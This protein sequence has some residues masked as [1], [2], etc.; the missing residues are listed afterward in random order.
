MPAFAQVT[1]LR[2][3]G[4]VGLL[5][6]TL[7]AAL[8]CLVVC[9]CLGQPV[10]AAAADSDSGSSAK[11]PPKD[12]SGGKLRSEGEEAM[13]SGDLKKAH[14][15]F[16]EAIQKEPQQ[17]QNYYK[18]F[19]V[20]LREKKYQS[21]IDDLTEAIHR[22]PDFKE[23]DGWRGGGGREREDER[24]R[25][26]GVPKPYPHSHPHFN[27]NPGPNPNRNPHPNPNRHDP[28]PNPNMVFC[29]SEGVCNI[30]LCIAGIISH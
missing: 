9:A 25:G 16:S 4:R 12:K 8:V 27:P 21:A 18:R 6:R 14:S 13:L 2:H 23:V 30:R 20:N 29:L 1:S 17:Y 7:F 11:Q 26:G 10:E 19:R 28:N 3:R 15:L 24:V 5:V 22:K